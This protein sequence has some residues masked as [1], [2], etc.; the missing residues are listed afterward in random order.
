MAKSSARLLGFALGAGAVL[1][2][3]NTL[4]QE[5]PEKGVSTGA[6][7]RRSQIHASGQDMVSV[8]QELKRR[9]DARPTLSPQQLT[10]LFLSLDQDKN[11]RL[12]R[13]ELKSLP[14][15]RARFDKF[16]ADGDHRLSYSEFADY[17][18]TA[19]DELAQRTP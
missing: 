16:D 9:D 12:T 8:Q 14:A 1:L 10:D 4:A 7:E 5:R 17:S 6:V 15:L 11:L 3:G 18:D 19:A 13:S 2:A